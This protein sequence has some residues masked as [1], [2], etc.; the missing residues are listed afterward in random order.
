MTGLWWRW[1]L[2]DL[3]RRWLLVATIALVIGLGTGTYAALLSTSAWREESNDASFSALDLHDLRIRLSTGSTVPAGTFTALV[4]RLPHADQVRGVRERLVLP[5]QL[6]APGGVLAGGELVGTATTPGE[7]VDAVSQAAGAGL[8]AT[9]SQAAQGR[10]ADDG[11]ARVVLEYSFAIANDLPTSGDL[12]LPGGT[13]VH[14]VGLGQSPEYFLLAGGQGG[15][16]FLADKGYAVVF[17]TLATAQEL[18]GLPGRVNDVVLTLTDP[19]AL[20]T[21]REELVAAVAELDPVVS[22]DITGRRDLRTY[23]VLYD[24]IAA[25][26]QLWRAVALLVLAG[27]AFAAMNLTTRVV[28]AQRREIGIGMALGVPDRRLAVRPLLFGGEV[29]LIGVAF[30]LLVGLVVGVPLRAVFTD[31]I[32]LPVWLTPFQP[33]VFAQAAA[34]GFVLPFAAVLLPV[35]RAVRVQPIDAIRVG[36][37][38][39]R[40]SSAPRMMPGLRL[41]G[42]SY[43]QVPVRNLLRTPRRTAL[44]ALGIAAAITTLVTTFGLLDT[45][46][47]TIDGFED[48]SLR[49]A[50]ERISVSLRE[51]APAQGGVVGDVAA[52]PETGAVATGLLLGVT[53]SNGDRTL[54]VVVEVLGPDAPWTPSLSSGSAGRGIVLADKAAADLG[55]AVGDTVTVAHPRATPEGFATAETPVAVAGTHPSPT[56]ILAYLDQPTGA[57]FGL[58]GVTNLLTVTPADGVGTDD[59]RRALLA[60]PEV[61]A[62]QSIR[63]TVDSMRS[64]MD[65]LMG[66]LRVAE[67]VTLLLALLIAFNT[68]SIGMDERVREHAT[69]LAFGLPVRTVLAMTTIETALV[70]VLGSAL[71][72]VGGYGMVQW[73]TRA[74]IPDVLPELQV[75]AS[76]T[77]VTVVGA[78]LLGV[79]TVAAA[80]LL[81]VRRLQRTDIPATLRVVE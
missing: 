30:G 21:V 67:A 38:A 45:F 46:G 79:A 48:E 74:T 19:A 70:G 63:T 44:T 2:R 14:Y 7:E 17:T 28:E 34:L 77:T 69:M 24:D 60:L 37:L 32:P 51:F 57:I 65:E 66:I 59:V 27:A 61:A 4:Q 68:A 49:S 55:V 78:I 72:V 43:H 10:G 35:W 31:I 54:D 6:E 1:S 26:E 29:A 13:T 25:D 73:I 50:P 75:T 22:A 11:V 20:R 47:A 40:R 62:T 80:P 76:L 16:P 23:R 36:H 5:T 15:P 3:R 41:P 33:G 58:D 71:G 9:E 8:A 12:V 42:R 18:A 81:T 52:L 53:V 64:S 56:S 39:G